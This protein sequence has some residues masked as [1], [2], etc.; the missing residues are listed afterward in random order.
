MNPQTCIGFISSPWDIEPTSV[1]IARRHGYQTGQGTK[2]LRY[3][4]HETES[5]GQPRGDFR[6][7]RVYIAHTSFD[8]EWPTR[9]SGVS[10]SGVQIVSAHAAI[11]RPLGA[12]CYFACRS[13]R[14]CHRES[15]KLMPYRTDEIDDRDV[16]TRLKGR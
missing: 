4:P 12:E 1:V 2:S 11:F 15:D 6:L 8:L 3:P 5:S 10:R 7:G 14:G 9:S 16:L 13:S